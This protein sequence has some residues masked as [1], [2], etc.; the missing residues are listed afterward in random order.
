MFYD[1]LTL[2]YEQLSN[3]GQGKIPL[4]VYLFYLIEKK[5]HER[6]PQNETL[7]IKEPV[8]YNNTVHSNI[9]TFII[10]TN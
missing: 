2:F 7:N 4:I 1:P 9:Y 5:L 3:M 8:T 10:S 6:H